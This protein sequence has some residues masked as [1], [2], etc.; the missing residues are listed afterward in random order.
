MEQDREPWQMHQYISARKQWE[1][2]LDVD[3]EMEG[4]SMQQCEPEGQKVKG[5]L[6]HSPQMLALL[7]QCK[8]SVNPA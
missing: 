4:V 6:K 3:R 5:K 2:V 8:A 7:C 1:I